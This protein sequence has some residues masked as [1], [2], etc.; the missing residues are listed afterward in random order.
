MGVTHAADNGYTD[1]TS[2]GTGICSGNIYGTYIHGFFDRGE[3]AETVV[4]A[5]AGK[6]GIEFKGGETVDHREFKEKEFDRLAD[7]LRSSLDMDAVYSMLRE[8]RI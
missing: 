5:L 8:A 2:D 4:R 1:F 7:I 3:V 6:K